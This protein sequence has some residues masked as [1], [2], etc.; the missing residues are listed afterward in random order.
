[1]NI[2]FIETFYGGSHKSF[3]DGLTKYSRDTFTSIVLP[4]RFWKWRMRS[5]A[6]YIAEN[7]GHALRTCDLIIATDL[8]NL[9]ELKALAGFTCPVI[10]FFHENQLTYPTPE[11]EKPEVDLGLANVVSALAAEVC[12]FNSHYQANKF[13]QALKLFIND[14]PEFVPERAHEHI[15]A[16]T[17]VM[18]MGMD[19]SGFPDRRIIKNPVPVILWNHRWEFDKQPHVFFAEMYKLVEEG[20]DFRL[21]IL[22]ENFQM[23]PKE[24]I[25]ARDRLGERIIQYGFVESIEDYAKF[26]LKSDI[27]LSTA[28]QENFGYA[29]AEAI[30]CY[31]LPLLP[32][33]LSYPE[34]LPEKFHQQFLYQNEEDLHQKL[35]LL[36]ASYRQLDEVRQQ[37]VEVFA[38]FDWKNRVSEFDELFERVGANRR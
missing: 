19:L 12:L 22:G 3:M 38:K 4:S 14:I 5:A 29:V 36:L 9:A 7:Y 18:Y 23:H 34:I 32:N 1:L 30:Y 27:I 35:K 26:V 31:T 20:L 16:K 13:D 8:L 17:Q 15:M 37:L 11:G 25:E 10:L 6:I 28:I 24:F 21:I 33:R 2:I